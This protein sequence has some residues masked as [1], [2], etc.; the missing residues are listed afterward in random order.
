MSDPKDQKVDI[1]VD[2]S[3]G[4]E[5]LFSNQKH[6]ALS[7]PAQDSEGKPAN[8]GFLIKY[9]CQT[10][11]TDPRADLFVLGDELRPGILCLINECDWE[12]EEEDAYVLQPG[13]NIL[14]ISTLH[15]G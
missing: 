4:L 7:V 12:L 6:H 10:L 14:F 9:L 13:D 11:M 3:G 8:V 1:T 5:I 15:G 2:F